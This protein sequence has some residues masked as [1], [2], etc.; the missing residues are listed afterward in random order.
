MHVLEAIQHLACVSPPAEDIVS[1]GQVLGD[2]HHVGHKT[3]D[4]IARAS[5]RTG[6]MTVRI[7]A[8]EQSFYGGK[9][10]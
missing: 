9:K 6:A 5:T 3:E 7:T 2:E 10:Q 4:P 1:W 8:I